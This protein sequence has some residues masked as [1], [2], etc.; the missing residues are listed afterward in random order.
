MKG[1]KNYSPKQVLKITDSILSD[2]HDKGYQK[3]IDRA[4]EVLKKEFPEQIKEVD[5]EKAISHSIHHFV[6]S[7]AGSDPYFMERI[8]I[9][10]IFETCGPYTPD[11]Q[12]E[13]VTFEARF[14]TIDVNAPEATDGGS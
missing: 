13:F 2:V 5:R 12:L 8:L 11:I 1:S 10:G 6:N 3:P 7:A 4:I 14:K 9:K